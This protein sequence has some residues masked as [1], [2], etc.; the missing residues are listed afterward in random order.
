MEQS[1]FT[2]ALISNRKEN[3]RMKIKAKL[4]LGV[5]SLFLLI[6][7]LAGVSTYYVN[8]LKKDT[9]NILRANYNT[10]EYGRGMLLTLD[11]I[12]KDPTAIE[13]FESNLQKQIQNETEPGEK[14]ATEQIVKHF[15]ALKKDQNDSALF[16]FLRRDITEVMRLNMEAIVRKSDVANNTAESAIVWISVTGAL[17]FLFAFVLLVN[18]PGNIADPIKELTV[19]IKQIAAQQYG[20]RVHFEGHSEFGELAQ[21]FNTMAQKL[22]EYSNSKLANIMKEKTRIETLINNMHD[23]VIGID[24]HKKILFA[25]EEALKVAGLNWLDIQ[26]RQ[27]QDIAVS[28]DLVRSLITDLVA[29]HSVS[30]NGEPIK[31]AADG[32]QQYF[33]KEVLDINIVPTGEQTPQLIGH[34]ILLK[35]ITPFK[36]LDFA[37]TNFIATVSHE[38]KTPI[39]SIKMS[40]NILNHARTG[41]LNEEQQQLLESIGDDSERL[42]KITS[43]LLNMSQVETGNIQLNIQQADPTHILKYAL[44][45]T[46]VSA[47]QKMLQVTT[48]V[49]ANL[50]VLSV[51]PE[52]T[53]WVLTNFITNA[54]RYAPEQTEIIVSLCRDND[55]ILFSVRDF[56]PGIDH[57]YQ[58]RI[59][60]RYFQIPGSSKAGTGLGLAI[61]KDFIEN[62]GGRIG[63]D[64][65]QGMGSTFYFYFP[66]R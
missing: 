58:E 19:S 62:Q 63:V 20:Q 59:F 66:I 12:Q 51:D 42:L 47:D 15:N 21:S 65:E 32:K 39:S 52:K 7:L 54:I 24:E 55:R 27:I 45:A 17:C 18:L 49:D 38:L 28:N 3:N 37:K 29:G 56:G 64:S 6:I 41:T 44:E 10:L 60:E 4:T 53:A 35:N 26:G 22:E 8:S 50:P 5:G 16:V 31:I 43:E 30:T 57:R 2:R 46:K 13:V 9:K 25:N 40:L 1:L 61:S 14:E 48:V 36:E 23:P 11:E 34:V 33:D